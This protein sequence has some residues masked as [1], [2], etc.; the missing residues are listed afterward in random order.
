VELAVGDAGGIDGLQV[1]V[2]IDAK[3]EGAA[4]QLRQGGLALDVQLILAAGQCQRTE[5]GESV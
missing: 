2:L 4:F 1:A 5:E 3:V